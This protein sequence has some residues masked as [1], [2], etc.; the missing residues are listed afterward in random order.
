MSPFPVP[1]AHCAT[2][3]CLLAAD[4]CP[5][6]NGG[7][8]P[9]AY[10]LLPM[11]HCPLPAAGCPLPTALRL[12]FY[13]TLTLASLCLVCAEFAF[14]PWMSY[15]WPLL[16]A[17]MVLAYRREGKWVLSARAANLLGFGIALGAVTWL[18]LHYW[19][20]AEGRL[21]AAIP[22]PAS[23]LPHLGPLLVVLMLVKLFRPKTVPDVWVTQGLGLM[24]VTL[25]GVL[26]GAVSF[27][28]LLAA[29]L[30][31][32]CWCLTLF[33]LCRQQLP[34]GEAAL[35]SSPA[36]PRFLPWRWLGL[37][38]A[39]RW[40]LT[41]L[42][43]AFL[44]F[45]LVPRQA[46][47]QWDPNLLSTTFSPLF[48]TGGDDNI[49]LN[50]VGPIELRDEVAFTVAVLDARG[51][52][53]DLPA[54]Q[55]WRGPTLDYYSQ[56]RWLP[57]QKQHDP[58]E[59]L[60]QGAQAAPATFRTNLILPYLGAEQFFIDFQV[61]PRQAGT[62]VLAEPIALGPQPGIHPYR[63][64]E[65]KSQ[66]GSFFFEIQG[67]STL[68]PV[69][70]PRRPE[71]RYRQVV[72]PSGASVERPAGPLSP[73]YIR[74]L[75]EQS[76]PAA[77]GAQARTLLP[78]LP[79]LG[80]RAGLLDAQGK[81]PGMHWRQSAE[82]L[83]RHLASSGQYTYSLEQPRQDLQA[84]PTVDFLLNVR[85]GHCS[86][87]A[88]GLT[89]LLRSLGIPARVI[90]GFLGA[91][92]QGE[93]QYVI[94]QSQAH[95]WVEVLVPDS[96]TP[97]QLNWLTLDPT[98]A[99]A[100]TPAPS[101][102]SQWL[103]DSCHDGRL[104][105]QKLVLDYGDEQ[106]AGLAETVWQSLQDPHL[107]GWVSGLLQL[108]GYLAGGALVVLSALLLGRRRRTPSAAPTTSPVSFQVR[109]LA[110]LA[111]HCQL[112]PQPAQT[113]REFAQTAATLLRAHAAAAHLAD[114]PL[115][116]A[117]CLYRLRYGGEQLATAEEQFFLQRIQE[118]DTTLKRMKDEG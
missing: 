102:W 15:V 90:K 59:A 82:A 113:P 67:N 76:V 22:W 34:T 115:Q 48:A 30:A 105:W 100:D 46:H 52:K 116:A 110:V 81:V 55:R 32:V 41:A 92:H 107:W 61:E 10:C 31:A 117:E 111:R 13:I 108:L 25:G 68:I 87:F 8:L 65:P 20:G 36:H 91:D 109:L 96:T 17:V 47:K 50:R 58:R 64:L 26:T 83:C 11:A 54:T 1:I 28:L 89:L 99:A 75:L 84:D 118:L 72:L 53:E 62:L 69:P 78:G 40:A 29:Y 63:N 14:L 9:L 86:R 66:R 5:L 74:Y 42:V 18:V 39:L 114:L 94:R 51:P 77:I 80:G 7:P 57:W 4:Y 70:Q 85:S 45:L 35:L 16:A 3:R 49:D 93:G 88:G 103:W 23:M 44:L 21:Q 112:R 106:Q 97:G 2:T 37:G 12:S 79:G 19:L 6:S 60:L 95:S 27:G 73:D 43:S 38:P 24:M 101:S 98:P 71:Y 104:L 56:G 33:F